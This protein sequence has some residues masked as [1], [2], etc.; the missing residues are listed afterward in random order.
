MAHPAA[1]ETTTCVP[2]RALSPKVATGAS[3][4]KGTAT[5]KKTMMPV[6]KCCAPTI[7]AMVAASLKESQESLPHGR[8]AQDSTT[9]IASRSG[10]RG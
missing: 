7:E 3:G 6:R 9:E 1:V 4:S 8:A 10:P 2:I 5:T